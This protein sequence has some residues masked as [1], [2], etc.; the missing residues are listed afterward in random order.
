MK[1]SRSVRYGVVAVSIIVALVL[2]MTLGPVMERNLALLFLA[3]VVFSSW[4]GGLGPGLL[5]TLMATL[6]FY[7]FFVEPVGVWYTG[8]TDLVRTGLFA[9]VSLLVSLLSAARRRAEATLREREQYYRLMVEDIKDYAIF[10]LNPDGCVSGWNAGAERILGYK[11]GEVI[12][13]H[14]SMFFTPEDREHGVP[15]RELITARD[16]GRSED[17]RW[18]LRKDGTRF[19]ASGVTTPVRDGGSRLVGF[20]KVMRDD[21]ANKLA[22]DERARLH[23]LE[24]AARHEAEAANRVKDEFL[25]TVSHELRTPLNSMLGW[26]QMLRSGRLNQANYARGLETVERNGRALAR[27]I[28]DILDVSRIV[29]GKLRLEVY[30]VD[31]VPI[32]N[33]AIDAVRPAAEARSIQIVTRL[34]P[35]AGPV[36]GDPDRLQQIVWNL[37]SNAIKFTPEGGR[38]E[39]ALDRVDSSVRIVVSDTGQGIG[40]DLLPHIF[41]RFRQADST[42][43]RSHGG[44]G[45]G[46]AITRHLVEMHGGT[47]TAESQGEGKGASFTALLPL[48]HAEPAPGPQPQGGPE[49]HFASLRGVKVL[50]VDD[51]PD[52]RRVLNLM[53]E[54]YGAE[55]RAAASAAEGLRVLGQWGPDVLISDIAMPVEDG[56]DLIRSV[57]AMGPG[58]LSR[59]PAIA[60]TGY[61]RS[62]DRARALGAGYQMHFAKPVDAPQLAE[63]VALLAGRSQRSQPSSR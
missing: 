10:M 7:V 40:Q 17:D 36:S 16:E 38:V 25:A 39:V 35:S 50:I 30:P 45:L 24:R 1:R 19:W 60:L 52:S 23:D 63:A 61:A 12:N 9:L 11:E 3:A 43:T 59:I 6:S 8:V 41:E 21:T 29:T 62:E 53:L 2:T 56:H 48:S 13:K 15:D 47:I 27:L 55:V 20:S 57:R 18:H 32:I 58:P 5:A 51:E 44:L 54:H 34:D 22:E 33:L 4:F 26:I 37:L 31:L 49:H 42:S 46:L 14:F 28:E